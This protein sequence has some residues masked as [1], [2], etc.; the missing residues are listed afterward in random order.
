MQH[1]KKAGELHLLEIPQEPWQEISI[2]IIGP[3]PKSNGKDAIIV[4]IDRFTKIV[5][6][7]ATIM[8]ISLKEIARIYRNKIWKLYSLE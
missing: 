3:L 8:N 2:N 5:R 1:Q 4:I 7:K 6:F